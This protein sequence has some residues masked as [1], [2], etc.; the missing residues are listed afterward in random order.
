M[1]TI[2]RSLVTSVA[3]F[4]G[5]AAFA[6]DYLYPT[7]RPLGNTALQLGGGIVTVIQTSGTGVFNAKLSST[8]FVPTGPTNSAFTLVSSNV[9]SGQLIH[10]IVANTSTNNTLLTMQDTGGQ[11]WIPTNTTAIFY[12]T[13][14]GSSF[15]SKHLRG[16]SEGVY[17]VTNTTAQW[18]TQAITFGGS[19]I[20]QSN[21]VVYLLTS[22]P[23]SKAWGATNKLGP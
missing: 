3:L 1:T 17:S 2:L 6:Q 13:S 5:V 21:H 22:T 4:L 7:P 11:T 19:V 20:V 12:L 15:Y 10:L 9:Q 16:A 8:F 23:G 14:D 18:P